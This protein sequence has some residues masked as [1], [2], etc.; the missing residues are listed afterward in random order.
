M[1]DCCKCIC[2]GCSTTVKLKYQPRSHFYGLETTFDY[3]HC[4]DCDILWRD[5]STDLQLNQY[6][7][8]YYSFALDNSWKIKLK[9][10][11][12]SIIFNLYY[13]FS[14]QILI[15][16]YLLYRVFR[17]LKINKD[18]YI[19]DVG[20]G[21]GTFLNRISSYGYKNILG[22]DPYLNCT[23]EKSLP[24]LP[25]SIF[26]LEEKFDVINVHHVI[27]H[28]PD[29]IKFL[30]KI[31]ASLDVGG[32][33]II[34]FPRWCKVVEEDGE[35]SYLIQA[36]D[37]NFLLSDVCFRRITKKIGFTIDY[38]E[39]DSSGTFEWLVI[40]NLWSK[41]IDVKGY[42]KNYLSLL[43]DNEIFALQT[44]SEIYDKSGEGANILYVISK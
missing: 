25:I 8:D 44:K 15:N 2:C 36:P 22:I 23:V 32:K 39:I 3:Y 40:G 4:S 16:D 6:G 24:V 31:Y 34:T 1:I 43:T 26:D 13:F 11:I 18:A 21:G 17:R 20:C 9:T 29:P 19:L 12:H 33:A 7:D 10:F 37:H 5:Q 42:D 14:I 41:N 35:N 28:V 30:E 27:E 38:S